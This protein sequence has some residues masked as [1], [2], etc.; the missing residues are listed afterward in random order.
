MRILPIL[1]KKYH[2]EKNLSSIIKKIDFQL[3]FI[4]LDCK[5][6]FL[7]NKFFLYFLR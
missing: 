5:K 3:L 7:T 1:Y 2:N 4:E 6:T